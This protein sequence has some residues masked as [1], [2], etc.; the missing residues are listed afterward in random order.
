[1]TRGK[2]WT[3]QE[4]AELKTMVE[5][6]ASI[7]EI[8]AKFQKSPGAVIVK[9]QRLGLLNLK[10]KGYTTTTI[11]LPREAPSSGELLQIL[12]GAIRLSMKPGLTKT[13]I[14]RLNCVSNITKAYQEVLDRYT[15]IAEV[16]I[17]MKRMTQENEKA[18]KQNNQTT[19]GTQ[20]APTQQIS[21]TMEQSQ[22][23]QQTT[24]PSS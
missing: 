23:N 22:P 19:E 17:Q 1:M 6:D 2:S 11:P 3:A 20:N 9:C 7:A 10:T 4:E 13:D 5:T 14:Q 8:A 18:S 15:R 12:A 16:E 24:T 21:G